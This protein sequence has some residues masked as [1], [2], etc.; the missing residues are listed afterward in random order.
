MQDL[1]KTKLHK[2]L[3]DIRSEL[4]A[5]IES[6]QDEY[7]SKGWLP[8]RLNLNRGVVRGMIEIWA[9]GLYQLYQF[10][11]Q[12]FVMIFPSLSQTD[13]LDM[14]GQQVNV[15]RKQCT[16]AKGKIIFRGEQQGNIRIPAGRILKTKPDGNGAIYRYVTTEDIVLPGGQSEILVPAESEEYGHVANAG[17]GMISELATNVPGIH[18]IESGQDWLDEEGADT[19]HDS[20]L[21]ARYELAW[22]GISGVNAAAYEKW[23]LETSG[24]IA[25]KIRD[26]HPRGQGTVDVVVRGPEG[27]PTEKLLSNVKD[28]VDRDRPMNDNVLVKGP[29]PVPLYI[30]AELVLTGGSMDAIIAEAEARLRALFEDPTEYPGVRPLQI[31]EDLTLDRLTTETMLAADGNCKKISWKNKGMVVPEDGLAVLEGINLIASWADK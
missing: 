1:V 8:T 2:S 5:H 17:P 24:V 4:F 12:L 22:K 20:D 14:H 19:E 10:L 23:A 15:C 30:D 27:V 13:W 26:R 11:A 29:R 28:R 6:V 25:V 7:Q 31:G 16:K 18:S 9:F 21:Q 3:D